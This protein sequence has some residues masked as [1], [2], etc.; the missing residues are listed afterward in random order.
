MQ[1]PITHVRYVALAV[2]DF[3]AERQFL[4]E[5]WCLNEEAAQD[6]VAYFAGRGSTEPFIVRLRKAE[7]RRTDLFAFAVGDRTDVDHLYASLR[8]D[9][10][11]LAGEPA[12][13]H[14][15][16][17]GYG[18]RFFDLDGRLV[19]ISADVKERVAEVPAAK[20]AIPQGLSHVVFHTPDVKKA[21]AWYERHLGLRVSDWLDEFMCFL[22]GKGSKHHCMAFLVGPPTLNHVAFEMVNAD[23]MMRGLGRMLKN[24]VRLTWGPGRHTAGDNTFAYF[25]SPAGNNLEYTA[26]LEHLPDDWQ[27]RTF[28]RSP[29]I[30]DQWGTGRIAGPPTYPPLKPDPALWA[31]DPV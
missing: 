17:G 11:K 6:G 2:E 14:S 25:Q 27:P 7:D 22:R 9:G 13:L 26:E 29:E 1:T 8:D 5:L 24:D 12:E 21:V 15:P 30:I 31:N 18:F 16:G 19:E 3:A 20:A 28:P 10:V 4:Q 23:E